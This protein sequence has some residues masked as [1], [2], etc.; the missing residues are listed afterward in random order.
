MTQLY[1][2]NWAL[3]PTTLRLSRSHLFGR[4]ENI[5]WRYW[6][7]WILLA[8]SDDLVPQKILCYVFEEVRKF[9]GLLQQRMPLRR[10][11]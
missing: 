5:W 2:L 11:G 9:K 1:G 3:P 6:Y 4:C 7:W 8:T 10:T